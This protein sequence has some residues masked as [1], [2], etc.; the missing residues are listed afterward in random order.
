M[1]QGVQILDLAQNTQRLFAAQ[2]EIEKR[3]LLNSPLSN[4]SW[5]GGVLSVEFKEPFDILAETV[6]QATQAEGAEKAKNEI[7]LPFVDDYRTKCIVPRSSFRL[8]LDA[9]TRLGLAA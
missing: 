6:H 5:R 4:S 2:P 9:V 8:L 3:K 7:W 1:D